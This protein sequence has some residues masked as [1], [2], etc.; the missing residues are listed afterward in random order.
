MKQ[1]KNHNRNAQDSNNEENLLLRAPLRKEVILDL[2][3][4]ETAGQGRGRKAEGKKT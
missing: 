4:G 1:N 3:V 2:F